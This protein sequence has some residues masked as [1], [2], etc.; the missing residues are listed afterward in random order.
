MR[1]ERP[2]PWG[3]DLWDPRLTLRQQAADAQ[4]ESVDVPDVPPSGQPTAAEEP[5]EAEPRELEP[6]GRTR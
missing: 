1:T 6:V 3:F 4:R 5:G 2:E